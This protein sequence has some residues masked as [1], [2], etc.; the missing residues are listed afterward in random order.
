MGREFVDLID[1]KSKDFEV[2]DLGQGAGRGVFSRK[3]FKPGQLV[4]EIRGQVIDEADYSSFYCMD[5]G[6]GR[7]LEPEVPGG[8]VNHSCDPNCQL[9][10]LGKFHLGLEALVN[11]EPGRELTYNYGWPADVGPQKCYCKSLKCRK[12]IVD[13]KELP[14]LLKQIKKAKKKKSK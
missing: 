2:C 11:I 7:V 3:Q 9:V 4:M 14:R 1:F 13:P 12:Y 8:L 6:K 10:Q 5:L